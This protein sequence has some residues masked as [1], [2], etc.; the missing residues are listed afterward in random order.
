MVS[1]LDGPLAK[2]IHKGFAGKLL[3]GTLTR[4]SAGTSTDGNGD[5]VGP[6]VSTYGFEGL[7]DTFSDQFRAQAGIPDGD[8]KILII[9]NSISVQPD[10]DDKVEIARSSDSQKFQIRKLLDVDPARATYTCQGF[11]LR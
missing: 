10:K 9:A 2:A 11:P 8:V 3:Q 4:V 1:F 6:S 5:P 7:V